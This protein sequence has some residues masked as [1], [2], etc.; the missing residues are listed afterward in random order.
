[1]TRLTDWQIKVWK[2][3]NLVLPDTNLQTMCI[4]THYEGNSQFTVS[5]FADR[6]FCNLQRFIG[7]A[8]VEYSSVSYPENRET[9]N[10]ASLQSLNFH[11]ESET[12]MLVEI[13]WDFMFENVYNNNTRYPEY[14]EFRDHMTSVA[15]IEEQKPINWA[16]FGF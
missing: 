3:G 10:N 1:M 2:N 15:L 16:Q 14:L 12:D 11:Y 9:I 8:T 13:T 7:N 6:S 4:N 5:F